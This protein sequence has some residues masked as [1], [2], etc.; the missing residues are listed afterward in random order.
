MQGI[1]VELTGSLQ[2][3]IREK[4]SLLLRHTPYIIR[5]NI[6][7]HSN[8]TRGQTHLYRASG[9]IEIGGPDMNASAEAPDAYDALDL[10]VGKFTKLLERRHGL[11]KDRRNHPHHIELH[12]AIPKVAAATDSRA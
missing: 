3:A 8:Q 7:L 1:Q 10:L 2:N 6:R 12:A 4:F 5:I 9:Q 11:R